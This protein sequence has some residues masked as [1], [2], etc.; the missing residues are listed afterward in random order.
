MAARLVERLGQIMP[1]TFH[2]KN[3][4]ARFPAQGYGVKTGVHWSDKVSLSGG[5][6]II[7]GKVNR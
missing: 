4:A 5:H 3:F 6:E 1:C 2:L 7:E